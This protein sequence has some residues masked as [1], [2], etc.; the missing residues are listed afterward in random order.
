MANGCCRNRLNDEIGNQGDVRTARD[1]RIVRRADRRHHHRRG[2]H[3][4]RLHRTGPAEDPIILPCRAE[5]SDVS[6]DADE[7]VKECR[8]FRDLDRLRVAAKMTF[9]LCICTL[10]ARK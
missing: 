1:E 10:V 4:R 7:R 9:L 8:E 6:R 5:Y 2:Y 3:R